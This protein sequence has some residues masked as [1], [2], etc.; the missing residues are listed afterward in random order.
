MGCNVDVVGS[1]CVVTWVEGSELCYTVA[2]GRLQTTAVGGI[3]VACIGAVSVSSCDDAA[4]D[5]GGV[6]IP[7]I[8]HDI[9]DRFA[10]GYINDLKV[11]DEINALL[12]VNLP[13]I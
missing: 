2:I 9:W 6:G 1:A 3:D 13:D 11:E 5:T 7:E 10:G 4:I 8:D 12:V